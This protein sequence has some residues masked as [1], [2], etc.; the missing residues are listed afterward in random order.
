MEEIRG[1]CLDELIDYIKMTANRGV[2]VREG[3]DPPSSML[4]VRNHQSVDEHATEVIL[5]VWDDFRR[6]GAFLVSDKKCSSLLGD[7][8]IAPMSRVDTT[9]DEGFVGNSEGLI[10]CDNLRCGQRVAAW[11]QPRLTFPT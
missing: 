8:Q 4:G 11:P 1:L 6:C 10:F 5:K 2:G 7:V 3:S 9:D